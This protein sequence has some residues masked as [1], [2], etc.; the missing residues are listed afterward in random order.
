MS[1][2]ETSESPSDS[3]YPGSSTLWPRGCGPNNEVVWWRSRRLFLEGSVR[4]GMFEGRRL[5][6]EEKILKV[7][8]LLS[9]SPGPQPILREQEMQFEFY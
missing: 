4:R 5:G 1:V 7:T 8:G 2:H 6:F 9:D 3:E